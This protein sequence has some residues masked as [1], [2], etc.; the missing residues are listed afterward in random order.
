MS[1]RDEALR[2]LVIGNRILAHQ[3]VVDAYGHISARHPTNPEHFLLSRSRAPELVVADD[4]MEFT[5]DGTVV[6]DDPRPPYLE[7]FIHGAIYES[8]PD[9]NAVVHSHAEETL[10]FGIT[11]VALQP[12]I[13]VASVIG[14]TI[15]VWDIAERFGDATNLLVTS[16]D[17]GRDL[18]QCL[19]Q[20]QVAL[21]RGHGFAAVGATIMDVV[22]V[23]VYLPVNARVLTT[24]MRF[25]P[26]KPLASG[27]IANRVAFNPRLAAGWRAWEYWA[28][29]AGVG[30]LLGDMP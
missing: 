27:E 26:F 16:V 5:L 19:G 17:Q 9:V 22:R 21:M 2:N 28:R 11:A 23:S 13:H 3:N 20:N 18:A 6:G 8:R 24:A 10:P 7:R 4:I 15:P 14:P 1:E 12:V 29:R 30:E 25:G